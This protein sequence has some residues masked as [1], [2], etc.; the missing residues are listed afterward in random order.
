MCS[1]AARCW[2]R[3]LR[4]NILCERGGAARRIWF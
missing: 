4:W 3:S 1:A 2:A